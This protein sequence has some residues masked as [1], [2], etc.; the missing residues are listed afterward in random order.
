M[1]TIYWPCNTL[2]SLYLAFVCCVS[3]F[4]VSLFAVWLV[5]FLYNL[6]CCLDCSVHVWLIALWLLTVFTNLSSIHFIV[7]YSEIMIIPALYIVYLN[8]LQ[9]LGT[10]GTDRFYPVHA[11]V[12]L[13][14]H[15]Y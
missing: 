8:F 13:C 11:H 5:Y 2:L 4:F 6:C 15:K 10:R 3:S 9:S 1:L 12:F 7:R 14:W